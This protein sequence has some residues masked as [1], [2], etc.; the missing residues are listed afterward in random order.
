MHVHPIT[1]SYSLCMMAAVLLH[2]VFVVPGMVQNLVCSGSSSSTELNF[3]WELPTELGNEA[4]GYQ[5][6]V[7][8]LEHR[9]GS[10]EVVQSGIYRDF[11]E[12]NDA[13]IGGLG[14][15]IIIVN[16]ARLHW[17]IIFFFTV[18]EVPYNITVKAL[19]LAGCGKE[20]QLYC[21]TQEGGN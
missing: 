13:S 17:F 3:S 16:T 15:D 8:R 6:T 11:I 9:T 7:N 19:N 2:V 1:S 14:N 10:R 18:S 5:V 21:F 20:Q 4:I 12:A